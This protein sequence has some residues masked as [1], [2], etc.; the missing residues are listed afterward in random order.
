MAASRIEGKECRGQQQA[1]YKA[2]ARKPRLDKRRATG[3][4]EH[5]LL[6]GGWRH[7]NRPK[8]FAHNPP[9]KPTI[10][11]KVTNVSICHKGAG[12][13]LRLDKGC[14]VLQA[15]LRTS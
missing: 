3:R 14:T 13:Y 11:Q 8:T 2:G 5:T 6:V 15:R 1:H 4:I 9:R 12:Y 7:L 10:P